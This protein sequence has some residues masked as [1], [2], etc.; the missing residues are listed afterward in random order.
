MMDPISRPDYQERLDQAWDNLLNQ[1]WRSR[2][3]TD[4]MDYNK[5][6]GH[7]NRVLPP[8]IG[9]RLACMEFHASMKLEQ[10]DEQDCILTGTD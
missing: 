5:T 7:K 1:T 3:D 9:I 8:D 10:D 4:I 6:H 2:K